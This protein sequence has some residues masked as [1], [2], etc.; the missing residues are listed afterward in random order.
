M[1]LDVFDL[2]SSELQ[3]KLI[4]ARDRFKEEEDRKAETMVGDQFSIF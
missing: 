4:P 3:Q 1:N 2:C